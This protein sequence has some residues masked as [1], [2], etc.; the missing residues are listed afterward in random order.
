MTTIAL[1][2]LGLLVA[3]LALGAWQVLRRR[4]LHCWLG[5]YEASIRRRRPVRRGEDVH[6][7]LVHRRPFRAAVGR[8]L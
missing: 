2:L 8:G 4:N 6:V 5:G 1:W 3:F 7:L